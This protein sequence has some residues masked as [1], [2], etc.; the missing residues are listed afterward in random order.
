MNEVTRVVLELEPDTNPI[1]GRMLLDGFGSRRFDG[2]VQ[3]IG[4]LEAIHPHDPDEPD[5]AAE[6]KCAS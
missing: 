5:P 3:L 4:L 1:S 6:R 2:Y